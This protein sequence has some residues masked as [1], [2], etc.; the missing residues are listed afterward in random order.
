MWQQCKQHADVPEFATTKP[1]RRTAL[2]RVHSGLPVV[3]NCCWK[4]GRSSEKPCETFE[5]AICMQHLCRYDA[6]ICH[7]LFHVYPFWP[8]LERSGKTGELYVLCMPPRHSL[9]AKWQSLIQQAIGSFK[10]SL[11]TLT[12]CIP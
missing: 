12:V 7:M 1:S 2:L 9:V 11:G 5:S 8:T 4:P 10:S 6:T 3:A